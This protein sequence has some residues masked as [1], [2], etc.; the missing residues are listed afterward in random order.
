MNNNQQLDSI[1]DHALGE[2]RDAEPLAGLED[3]VLQRLR[4]Q[5][6]GS[7]I[8]SWKWGMVAACA[9]MLAFAVWLGLRGNE[10]QGPIARRQTLASNADVLPPAKPA[11]ATPRAV[12]S[13]PAPLPHSRIP[14]Q[15]PRSAVAQLQVAQPEDNGRESAHLPAPLT[16]EER[17]LLALAQ[18]HPDALRSIS[19]QDQP[20]AI[21]PLTIEPLPSEA[22]ENGDN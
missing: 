11:A 8:A 19:Q 9:A 3:R 20:I 1:L 21:T 22:N 18:T 5:P 4:L 6:D 17:Q 2:Y 14:A 7:R 16:R 12:A 15:V 10:P 13:Q